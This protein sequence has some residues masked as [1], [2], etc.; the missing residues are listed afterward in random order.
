MANPKLSAGDKE[1]QGIFSFIRSIRRIYLDYPDS[2]I[3]VLWDGRSWRKDI[4]VTYK[5]KR[6]VTPQQQEDRKKYFDQKREMLRALDLLG[7]PHVYASNMEADDLAEIHSRKWKG[8]RVTLWSGDKDWLQLVDEKISWYD[9]IHNRHCDHLNFEAFTGFKN[10]EQ[11]VEA[12]CI[13][14]DKDEVPGLKGIGPKTLEKVYE[15]W[16][17][18]E[19]GF[20]GDYESMAMWRHRFGKSMP[21]VLEEYAHNELE[22]VQQLQLNRKLADLKTPY[23]PEPEGL[24]RTQIPLDTEKFKDFC[25]ENGFISFVRDIDRFVQPFKEN[26]F[27]RR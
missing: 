26:K 1:T 17:S 7:V 4:D 3:L 23:R 24:L 19:T 16:D 20:L 6:E 10:T 5:D 18:F 22:T 14:G 15:L 27:V 9:P 8:D 13:L 12:K 21:S 25:Y 2:L 11:F